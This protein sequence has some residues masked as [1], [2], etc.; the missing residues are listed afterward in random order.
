MRFFLFLLTTLPL[1]AETSF[2]TESEYAQQLYNNP[3]GIACGLCHGERGE[4]KVIAKYKHKNKLKVFV[5][6]A[7]NQVKYNEFYR[8]LNS[9]KKGMPRYYLTASEIRALYF[10]LHQYDKKRESDDK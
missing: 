1:F 3:R 9:R 5:G 4:G 10:Y 7:I 6:P 2:I 8:A